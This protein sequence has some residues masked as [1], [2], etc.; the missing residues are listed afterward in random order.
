MST[1]AIGVANILRFCH[2]YLNVLL[3]CLDFF[4]VTANLEND[5]DGDGSHYFSQL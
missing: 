2:L 4:H 5:I 1:R 3:I